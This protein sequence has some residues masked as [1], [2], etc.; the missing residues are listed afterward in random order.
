MSVLGILVIRCH[1]TRVGCRVGVKQRNMAEGH[2]I[3]RFSYLLALESVT[4]PCDLGPAVSVAVEQASENRIGVHLV[5]SCVQTDKGDVSHP[6]S[7]V[8]AQIPVPRSP[9]LRL[10]IHPDPLEMAVGHSP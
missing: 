3:R 7:E 9:L 5:L 10:A 2:K 1:V 6:D 4:Q 8:P